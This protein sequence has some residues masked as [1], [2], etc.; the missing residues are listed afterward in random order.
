MKKLLISAAAL[1]IVATSVP[2]MAQQSTVKSSGYWIAAPID[3]DDGKFE[4]YMDYLN[5]VWIPNQEH[6]KSQGWITDYHVLTN[7]NARD[8]EPDVVLLTRFAEY[9]SVAEQERRNQIINQR[10]KW[11]DHSADTASGERTKM[12]KLMGSIL[13]QEQVK[14]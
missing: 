11:D 4:A 13:Y 9:P 1:T 12:R 5:R 6:A 7:V 3:T 10:N 14:R 8:G 2:A